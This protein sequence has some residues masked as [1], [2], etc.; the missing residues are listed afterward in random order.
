MAL[1]FR[2]RANL[3]MKLAL[4]AVAGAAI[5]AVCL[6]WWVP[7]TDYMTDLGFA[8]EQPVPFSHKHH[9]GDDGLDCRYCHNA[10]EVAS[11][12]G[13]PSTQVCMT[14][15]SQL[16]TSAPMLAPVRESLAA[17]KNLRWQAV[18]LVPDYVYFDHSI[19]VA[20]GVACTECHGPVGDMP[21]TWKGKTLLM[22][23][24]L[25]CHRN[26]APHLRPLAAVFDP[27]WHRTKATPSG[28][29][30]M[31]GYQ[32]HSATYLTDC[33]VCHR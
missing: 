13:M 20:K 9:V 19:H 3:Y 11:N 5:A 7:H 6:I 8:P 12:A 31:K 10:V 33:S 32:I 30:L 16:W 23:F 29:S 22:Q 2:P 14:C 25:D 4:M 26:P 27:F 17:H 15:H 28:A 24:C 21:L 1:I 18:N